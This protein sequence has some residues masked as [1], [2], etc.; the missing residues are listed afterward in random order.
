MARASS[1][2][3]ASASLTGGSR[4][5]PTPRDTAGYEVFG[6]REQQFISLE[7]LRAGELLCAELADDMILLDLTQH[8]A[9]YP[10]PQST[11]YSPRQALAA[12]AASAG[13]DGIV[14]PVGNTAARRHCYAM[15]EHI[16]SYRARGGSA[17]SNLDGKLAPSG[18]HGGLGAQLPLRVRL[19]LYRACAIVVNGRGHWAPVLGLRAHIPTGLA[20]PHVAC[21]ISLADSALLH[22]P[23]RTASWPPLLFLP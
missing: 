10:V 8:A 7:R 4:I 19:A 6:R 13:F 22:S 23:A 9:S 11:R 20:C 3:D 16:C 21:C 18:G 15:F 17:W 1:L 5:S 12:E 14:L 2:R